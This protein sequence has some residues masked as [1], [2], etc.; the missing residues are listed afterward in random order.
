MLVEPPRRGDDMGRT[1]VVAG[2]TSFYL[3][4]GV[5][6]FPIR[7][8]PTC[9][10]RWLSGGVF[11]A[12][13]HIARTMRTLGGDIRLCTVVGSDIVGAGIR[14]ELD[15]DGLL[16]PG[17]IPGHGSS[18]GV[19]LVGPDGRRMGYPHLSPVNDVEYPYE[20]FA[21]Q[22]QGADL[23][24]MTN[25]KFVRPLVARADLLGIPI[26]VDTHLIADL[27]DSY[28]QPWLR[29][30]RIVFSSHERLPVPPELWIRQIFERYPR[31]HLVG[32]GRG[33]EGAMLGLRD[34]RLVTVDAA[35]PRGV[36]ST[37]GAGDA[38]FATFLHFWVFTGDPVHALQRAVLHAG[39]K[40]GDRIPGKVALTLTELCALPSS[41][42]EVSRWDV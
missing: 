6:G 30:A 36:V 10:P 34:G 13:A 29:A 18:M 40:I 4:L 1:I 24:V 38:L 33:P 42:T 39:W 12:A 14:A 9:T 21:A 41:P 27:S 19:V 16:G 23:L 31:C 5:E 8:L 25:A 37:S 11:G 35:A 17:V 3:S 20:T 32:V 2:A 26:A 22:A 15:H 28:S 7:Y